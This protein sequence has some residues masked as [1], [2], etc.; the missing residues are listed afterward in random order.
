MSTWPFIKMHGLGN[1]FVVLDARAHPLS[2][3]PAE[4]RAIADRRTGVGC[5]QL[6]IVEPSERA[7]VFMRIRNADGGE[8]AACG[9]GARC[10]GAL[11]LAETGRGE[12]TIETLAGVLGVRGEGGGSITVDM[13]AP[14]LGWREIP[15][16]E[17]MDTLHVGLSIGPAS[18]PVLADPVAVN[19]GNPHL[20]FFVDDA[21]A[22]DLATVGPMVENHPLLPERANV[23]VAHLAAPDTLRLRVWERG[24][25]ITSACGTGA[26]AAAVAAS[27]RGLAGRAID[28]ELDG[29]RLGLHWTDDDHVLMTGP[30]A[31]S[32]SGTLGPEFLGR[33]A[34]A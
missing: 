25:G 34:A 3:G 32:F 33:E 2:V 19:M 10:V 23:S 24:V 26:C 31:T 5:D 16:T 11:V 18:A 7:D 17:E 21:E 12:A 1:D 8:V 30:I 29:G 13:G 14:A 20:V 4:A 27:R 22:V 28:V 6:L 15:L 9:N